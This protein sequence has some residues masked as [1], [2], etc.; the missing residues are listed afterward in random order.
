MTPA[1]ALRAA[2]MPLRAAALAMA[3]ATVV[4][5]VTPCRWK[6]L[7]L[8]A[9]LRLKTA[10]LRRPPALKAATFPARLPRRPW[11]ALRSLT[12]RSASVAKSL[13]IG[14]RSEWKV[15]LPC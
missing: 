10:L 7:R 9:A 12:V 3:A 1:A 14:N 4:A 6:A 2:V 5:A 13:R 11:I 15:V 8:T